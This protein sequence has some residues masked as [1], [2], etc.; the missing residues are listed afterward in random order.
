MQE[1]K[2]LWVKDIKDQKNIFSS[3]LNI[4]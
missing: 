3:F 4:L 2:K 1:S